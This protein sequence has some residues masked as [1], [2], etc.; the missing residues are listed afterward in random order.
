[1]NDGYDD[2]DERVEEYLTCEIVNDTF[3]L[4]ICARHN[5]G[6]DVPHRR[7]KL[8]D[9]GTND[10]IAYTTLHHTLIKWVR[11]K[12]DE[13]GEDERTNERKKYEFS[14]LRVNF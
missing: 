6:T 4:C 10:L 14:N 7:R 11:E 3:L 9:C 1:M 8:F 2:S 13:N 12:P 5:R